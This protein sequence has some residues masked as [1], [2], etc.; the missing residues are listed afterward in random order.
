MQ[1]NTKLIVISL[2][3][4]LIVLG[5]A[6]FFIQRSSI[7]DEVEGDLENGLV[8]YYGVEKGTFI[9]KKDL[10]L[11]ERWPSDSIDF[12]EARILS[13]SEDNFEI[14]FTVENLEKDFQSNIG[15]F[16][17]IYKVIDVE[18]DIELYNPV[19][20]MVFE[21]V[22]SMDGMSSVEK[23]ISYKVPSYLKGDY[24]FFIEVFNVDSGLTFDKVSLGDY[25]LNGSDS[26]I[27]FIDPISC[28]LKIEGDNR[29]YRP[30]FGVDV[31][32]DDHFSIVCEINNKYSE[33]K[34]VYPSVSNFYRRTVLDK[35]IN[36]VDSAYNPIYLKKGEVKSISIPISTKELSSQA[37]EAL[38][39]FTDEEGKLISNDMFFHYVLSGANMTIR[40]LKID[41]KNYTEGEEAKVKI[42]WSGAMDDFPNSRLGNKDTQKYMIDLSIK[43]DRGKLCSKEI[44]DVFLKEGF[45]ELSLKIIND[46]KNAVVEISVK[47]SN[48]KLIKVN[49]FL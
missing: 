35:K 6:V 45:D 3:V 29:N 40:N 19:K 34:L 8:S 26:N 31:S 42:L 41:K 13:R 36:Q 43:N 47:D 27:I 44:K 21:E 2:A 24:R 22:F 28:H 9:E 11:V 38:L 17:S 4:I 20:S 12:S 16:L 46:C 48:G 23:T 30:K 10:D 1:K 15:Y 39:E 18:S 14:K 33:D 49:N 25:Q 5:V 7:R 37:Y 32:S